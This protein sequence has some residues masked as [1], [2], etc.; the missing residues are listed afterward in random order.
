MKN[1]KYKAVREM[2]TK[3]APRDK[4]TLATIE[5]CCDDNGLWRVNGD[6]CGDDVSA[7]RVVVQCVE[8]LAD[9]RDTRNDKAGLPTRRARLIGGDLHRTA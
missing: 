1:Q 7:M 5:I 3:R 8:S 6:P 2:S 4:G 9:S